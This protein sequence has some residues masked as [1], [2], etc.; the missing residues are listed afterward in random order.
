VATPGPASLNHANYIAWCVNRRAT[1]IARHHASGLDQDRI[2]ERLPAPI[3][4][5]HHLRVVRRHDGYLHN[6]HG[7]RE[8]VAE[9]GAK[10]GD[11]QQ[12]TASGPLAAL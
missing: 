11:P 9:R 10:R 1:T 12:R 7:E 3:C 5:R 8:E 2:R 4:E 6:C